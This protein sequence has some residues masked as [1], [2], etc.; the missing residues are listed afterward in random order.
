MLCL[1]RFSCQNRYHFAHCKGNNSYLKKHIKCIILE[2]NQE[3][4]KCLLTKYFQQTKCIISQKAHSITNQYSFF[5]LKLLKEEETFN[6]ETEAK[7]RNGV[8]LSREPSDG[9][10]MQVRLHAGI[11][12]IQMILTPTKVIYILLF[13]SFFLNMKW[14]CFY[15]NQIHSYL[16]RRNLMDFK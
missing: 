12:L 14:K 13:A 16:I 5:Y 15:G 3:Y 7:D 4:S 11:P 9:S 8:Q 6:G 1:F 10:E 2:S